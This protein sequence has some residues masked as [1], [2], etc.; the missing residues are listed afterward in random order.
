MKPTIYFNK[1]QMKNSPILMALYKSKLTRG[2]CRRLVK[3]QMVA[4]LASKDGIEKR[5]QLD[6]LFNLYE[7]WLHIQEKTVNKIEQEIQIVF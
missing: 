3:Q 5:K 1:S 7:S 2:V 4:H 6:Q